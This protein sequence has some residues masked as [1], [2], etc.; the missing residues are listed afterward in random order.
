VR[1]ADRITAALLLA[2]ALA[3]CA[4]ALKSYSWWGPGGPGS[5]FMPFWV[6]LAMAVLAAMLLARS[7]RQREA[8]AAWLPERADLKH[9][10]VVLAVTVA[11]VVLL[12]TL[13]TALGSTLFL[14]VLMRYLGRHAWPLTLAVA[15]AAA[16]AN[17][18]VFAHWLRVPFPEG[19]LGF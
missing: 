16:A 18:L 7:L 17:W 1:S 5:A 11:L 10:A 6:G 12:K 8:G 14:I 15:V 19:V 2:F 13:G 3:F 4:G 9:V